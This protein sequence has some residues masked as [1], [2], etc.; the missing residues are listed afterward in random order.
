MAGTSSRASS[1]SDVC[2]LKIGIGNQSIGAKGVTV[3]G[4]LTVKKLTYGAQHH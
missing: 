2:A 1:V 3:G 4:V